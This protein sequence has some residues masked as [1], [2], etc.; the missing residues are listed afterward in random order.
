MTD[1]PLVAGVDCSTQAT[2]VLVV[3]VASG[4][5]VAAGR[6]AHEVTGSAGKR[7]TDPR[8]WWEALRSALSQSG[9]AGAVTAIA[10]AGQQ[11]GL[12]V[13]DDAGE[14]LR[15]AMLWND[16]RSAREAEALRDDIGGAEAWAEQVGLVPVA[17]F[18]VAKWAWLRSN[19]PDVAARTRAVRL[20][21][22]YLTERLSGCGATDRGD[23]SGTGWWSTRS[24]DY[25]D[26][27]LGLARVRLD[28]ALLPRVLGP[29]EVAGEVEPVVAAELG[30]AAGT[31]V[32]AGTGD[33]MAAA[34][35]LG[36]EPGT[37]V[38]SLG[39]S[40]TAYAVSR[41]RVVDTS[42]LVAGFADATGGFLPLSCTLNCTL[43]VDRVA[44]LLGLD[45]EDV[46]AS[47][48]CIMLPYLDGE[49]TP[50]LPLAAGSLVGLRHDTTAPQILRA[51]YE[52]AVASLL[53]ALDAID[54]TGAA[55]AD[56]APLVLIGGGS[57]GAAWRDVVAS[58]SGRAIE[59]PAEQELVAM[60]AAVQ[61]AAAATGEGLVEVAERW[62]TRRGQVMPARPADVEVMPRIREVQRLLEP[63]NQSGS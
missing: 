29:R 6:H 24:E 18:T 50:N 2:K 44:A 22:D 16:I 63:L 47:T 58:L 17:S 12:V 57:R 35:G 62:A 20:P 30:L 59:V 55:L 3:D 48:R 27:V 39:T 8:Q 36:L 40:G 21:H 7:E 14:P 51:A 38:I 5:V 9:R 28:R 49:R 13:L 53:A 52:G 61:A 46:A 15:P 45:R 4:T 1:G 43:A 32:A 25:A 56:D 54:A 37:P 34:L 42:G 33:N 11:H 60:G 10:V 26:D 19:E 41:E 31:V 23:A